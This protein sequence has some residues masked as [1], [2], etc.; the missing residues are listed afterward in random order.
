MYDNLV[1]VQIIG[2]ILNGCDVNLNV[3]KQYLIFSFHPKHQPRTRTHLYPLPFTATSIATF[4]NELG[5]A[6]SR[7]LPV[8][9]V[10]TNT[11]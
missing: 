6:S 4:Y 10:T 3:Y 8:R 5:V 2:I 9:G 1:L 7:Q 11:K